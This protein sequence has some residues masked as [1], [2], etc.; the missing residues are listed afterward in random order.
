M[1][2]RTHRRR[3][4]FWLVFAASGALAY[5][6]AFWERVVPIGRVV[7]GWYAIFVIGAVV[8]AGVVTL[9]IKWGVVQNPSGMLDLFDL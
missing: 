2:A 8:L 3:Y 4:F 7:A 1:T 5:G 6:L 9:S